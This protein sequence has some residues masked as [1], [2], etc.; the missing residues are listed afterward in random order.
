MIKRLS[1]SLLL[2][3]LAAFSLGAAAFA[4]FSDS[5]AGEV[6]ITSGTVDLQ[7]RVDLNCD[8]ESDGDWDTGWEQFDSDPAEFSWN[9]IVPGD[10]TADCIE[11]RNA[12][13]NGDLTV[14]A[15]HDNFGGSDDLRNQTR[16]QYNA[17]GT[18]SVNCGFS[19]P[20]HSQYTSGRGCL[21]DT[22]A[23]GESFE[24]RVDVTFLDSGSNQ[25]ALQGTGFGFDT[26]LTGY[27]G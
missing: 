9:N 5:G 19:T 18:G 11:V 7:F 2:M 20:Q 8:R 23:P 25:N 10:A 24:L 26:A 3:G 16:W 6:A 27:T 14:Y 22:I 21:L 12:G 17:I 13:P 15:S 4:W 1:I